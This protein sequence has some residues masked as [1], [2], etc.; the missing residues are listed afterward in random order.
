[1]NLKKS[2]IILDFD[3][4]IT[5]LNIDL[6]DWFEQVE[7]LFQTFDPSFEADS[8]EDIINNRN[9]F[10]NK[11]GKELLVKVLELNKKYEQEHKKGYTVLDNTVR[12]IKKYRERNLYIWSNNH[13]NTIIPILDELKITRLFKKIIACDNVVQLKPDIEGFMKICD[14]SNSKSDYI[15]L[16]DSDNDRQASF[17]SGID[18]LSI[19]EIETYL[20]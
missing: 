7:M 10:V 16:G 17:N 6:T 3:G 18:F 20:S 5:R 14:H 9:L 19:E 8:P 12:F 2:Y 11:Y 4:T 13:S 1:M 15:L